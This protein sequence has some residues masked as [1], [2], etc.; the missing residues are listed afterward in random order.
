MATR[1]G[2]GPKEQKKDSI[3]VP[4]RGQLMS[5]KAARMVSSGKATYKQAQKY[6]SIQDAKVLKTK[7]LATGT[8]PGSSALQFKSVKGYYYDKTG[9]LKPRNK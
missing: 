4:K 6:D 3:V 5:D 7:D 2:P 8:K 9:E 1:K